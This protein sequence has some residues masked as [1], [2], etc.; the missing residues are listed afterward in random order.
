M[1]KALI[2]RHFSP[3]LPE[4]RLSIST[5]PFN[6]KHPMDYFQSIIKTT[7]VWQIYG[8]SLTNLT[9]SMQ[10]ALPP[11]GKNFCSLLNNKKAEP[12][13]SQIQPFEFGISHPKSAI[14]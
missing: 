6:R 3:P 5:M 4:G 12:D 11:T 7:K 14:H 8:S 13:A 10:T 1:P 2:R 9:P